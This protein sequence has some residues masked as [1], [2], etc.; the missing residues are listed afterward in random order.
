MVMMCWKGGMGGGE[1]AL[2]RLFVCR[3]WNKSQGTG[4]DSRGG[5][6]TTKKGIIALFFLSTSSLSVFLLSVPYGQ[7]ERP[8]GRL[9]KIKWERN[10][11]RTVP[12]TL[13]LSLS[14]GP[15]SQRPATSSLVTS[16][17]RER[18]VH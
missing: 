14:L 15:A 8:L 2:R 5:R 18:Q 17:G 16:L 10:R 7:D 1:M 4:R 3:K 11:H 12:S 9:R 6:V 13:S